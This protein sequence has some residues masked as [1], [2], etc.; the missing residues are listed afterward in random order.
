MFLSVI[1]TIMVADMQD[2]VVT[3]MVVVMVTTQVT[4]RDTLVPV[5]GASTGAGI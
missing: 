2:M 3:T 1:S 4:T 5:E